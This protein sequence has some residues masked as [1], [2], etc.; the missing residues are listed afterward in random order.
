MDER[1]HIDTPRVHP[2]LLMRNHSQPIY[3]LFILMRTTPLISPKAP[4]KI[5]EE[6]Y[7]RES[8]PYPGCNVTRGGGDHSQ[9][10]AREIENESF[11]AFCRVYLSSSLSL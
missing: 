6:H 8:G 1:I 4:V 5:S 2:Y 9:T 11:L 7:H 10:A 3:H